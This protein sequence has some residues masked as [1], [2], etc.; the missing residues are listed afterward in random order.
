VSR[1]KIVI[2]APQ[3]EKKMI[4]PV[5]A[6]GQAVLKKVATP[7]EKDFPNLTELI[8]NMWETMY[9]ASGMGLAAPQIG[10]SARLFIVDTLQLKDE[11]KS[12]GGI[13]KVFINAQKIEE[14]GEPW[15][16]EEG[17]LSIPQIT[18]DVERPAQIKLRYQ[19]ENL[20]EHEE[21]FTGMNA[22]VIQHEYD[23]IDGILFLEHLKP[24]KRRLLK[25]KLENIKKGKVSVDYKMK[26]PVKK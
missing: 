20:E 3:K 14:G 5:Y 10:V 6:Y 11:E 15:T 8:E 19:D 13:K 4:L 9:H 23:H 12:K 16:Y 17:C 7:I 1:R 22:R 24:I 25:R 21:I 2:F 26:F 18:G